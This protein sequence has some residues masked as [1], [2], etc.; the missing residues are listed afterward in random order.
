ME[1]KEKGETAMVN[2]IDDL[3][4]PNLNESTPETLPPAPWSLWQFI[5]RLFGK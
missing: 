1:G 5:R 2:E 4:T 3:L